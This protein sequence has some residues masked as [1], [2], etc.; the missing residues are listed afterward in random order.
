MMLSSLGFSNVFNTKKHEKV[1]YNNQQQD[2]YYLNYIQHYYNN[3]PV[4][5]KAVSFTGLNVA[6]DSGGIRIQTIDED[7][8]EF[9][10]TMSKFENTL[11][12]IFSDHGNSYTNFVSHEIEGRFEMFHASMFMLIPKAVK[13]FIGE[14]EMHNLRLNQKRLFS[15]ADFHKML[16]YFAK[17][18]HYNHDDRHFNRGLAEL[19]PN[20]RSC[21][22]LPLRMPNLCLCQNAYS[23][24]KNKNSAIIYLEF[25][26]GKLNNI[27]TN[28]S[29]NY[30]CKRLVPL[31]FEIVSKEKDGEFILTNF[32]IFT[33]PGFGSHN[34][35]EKINVIIKSIESETYQ[36]F[37]MELIGWDRISVFGDYERC[38]DAEVNFKLCVCDL[39]NAS[40][41]KTFNIQNM[42]NVTRTS[43][44]YNF[45]SYS[46]YE[47]VKVLKEKSLFLIVR[48]IKE[49]YENIG[50]F[51]VSLTFEAESVSTEKYYV[52]V[53]VKWLQNLKASENSKCQGYVR[54]ASVTYLCTYSR[55]WIRNDAWFDY[56]THYTKI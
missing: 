8:S 33:S 34:P 30:S 20:D 14:E 22:N 16:F 4:D 36:N 13:D 44:T 1:C 43:A 38:S 47:E 9:V 37:S 18:Y 7:L 17:K 45:S 3:L 52:N 12:V 42:F 21:D 5:Q 27:I 28:S 25:A 56:L 29:Q 19:I 10:M 50:Q 46:V 23:T 35:V 6:H 39:K 32:D 26:V 51:L 49:H 55:I 15:M 40:S 53:D 54:N 24:D 31:G 11:T 41:L 2:Y 48:T